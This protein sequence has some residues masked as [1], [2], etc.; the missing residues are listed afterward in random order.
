MLRSIFSIV[1]SLSYFLSAAQ[2]SVPE[3][4]V[5][6]LD[7]FS[8]IRPQE[9]AYVQTDRNSYLAGESI[10]FKTYS[11]LGGKPTIL[12]KVIYVDLIDRSGMV[13]DKKM[14]KLVN[15][16][17]DGV[18]DL[19]SD[20]PAGPYVLRCYT[21]WMLNF[22][23]FISEKRI[24][25][26]SNNKPG[27]ETT[28][29]GNA[30]KMNFFPE[31]G[32]LVAGL[33]STVAY[34]ALDAKGNPVAVSGDIMNSKNEKVASF[35]TAH[36]GMGSFELQP[37][38]N[39]TYKA[40]VQAGTGTQLSYNLPAIKDEGIVFS[41]DNSGPAKIF[42]KAARTEKNKEKYN[43][44]LVMAQLNYQVAYMGKFNFEEGLDAAAINKKN[45]P[46]GI[47]QIT[48]LTE[49]GRP[50]AERLVFIAN[51]QA[52]NSLLLA[53]TTNTDKRKKNSL[54]L[55]AS[56]FTNLQAAVSVINA[57]TE[58]AAYGPTIQSSL[59]LSSD[60]KGDILN[61]GYYFKDKEAETLQHLDLLMMVHGWRR[62]NLEEIM[63]NKFPPL[64]YPFE[65]GLSITGKV[66]QSNGKSVL[67]DGKINMMIKAEDSS[68][69]MTE[70]KTNESSVFV[71]PDIDFRKTATVYYQGSNTSKAEGI[72][73]VKIDS[74]YFD[75]LAKAT[76]HSS[77]TADGTSS[78]YL[79][80]LA[81]NQQPDTSKGKTLREVVLRARK[82][83][84]TDSLNLLYASDLF[85]NSDQNLAPN[86]NITYFDIWQFLRMN[87]P[88]IIIDRADTGTRVVFSRY[89]GLDLFSE[90]GSTSVQFFL[91]EVPVD[92]SLIENIDP[93]DVGLIKIYKGNTGIALGATRGA[94]AVYTVKGKS[95]RDWRDKGFDFYKRSGYSVSREFYAMDYS[96]I[97]PESNKA[98]LRNTL[99]WEP[100]L[101]VKD[102]KAII[103]FY[104][105]DVCRKFK[106]VV[107]GV[108]K[109][110]KLLH[111]E[112]EIR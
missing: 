46:P 110:G 19:K 45:L 26:L 41:V 105:D 99:Y 87:V 20:I 104:N 17:A 67:K 95:G 100:Q 81:N 9:K 24:S 37:A 21:L 10:W 63:A 31:G 23:E 93:A 4:L 56:G 66:L 91:N 54:T 29:A 44:L 47:M 98:D 106:V 73:T 50:L 22:P 72:V 25:I 35:K 59:L 76:M 33:K 2:S 68:K 57:E 69:I 89:D 7:S 51:Q 27:G 55:D 112:K 82:R 12:S 16:T 48:V 83:S 84:A 108:D 40:F 71:V 80:Q 74:A 102:G 62:F 5:A 77:L 111:A 60:L 39:E 14:M 109:D 52:G 79:D 32:N 58:T 78:S 94:I 49:D 103:E 53:N 61:P 1:F 64:R 92:I 8:F 36:D 13:L 38:A 75:T 28:A 30:V 86:P 18:I 70:A 97:K 43:A 107:E 85:F 15:G 34:K 96:Q 42:I 88:G 101:L 3:K 6:A 65:T 90:N 11:V